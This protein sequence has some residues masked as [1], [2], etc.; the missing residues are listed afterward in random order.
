MLNVILDAKNKN[1][2]SLLAIGA[3]SDDLE[4]GCG[5]T[6]LRLISEWSNLEVTWVVF[7]SNKERAAEATR[8]ASVMLSPVSRKVIIVRDFKD[9]FLPY[10]GGEVK[11]S[12]EALK[13]EISPDL[14]LTHNRHDLHQD[15][16]L[17]SELTW[18]TFRDHLVLEYE[19]PKYDGDFG[20]PNFFVNIDK[21]LCH[22]KAAHIVEFFPS[23]RM[24]HWFSED[25]FMGLA[26]LRGMEANSPTHFAEGFYC[27]K[28]V[29]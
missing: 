24:K 7:C 11:E 13:K 10:N 1:R 2:M 20:S 25:T 16:R 4:I 18:N 15:H 23:Q 12:F 8:S 14:I 22:R 6:I 27:R 21:E 9:G 29:L 19:I 5:G 17:L 3:H 26:R 28:V